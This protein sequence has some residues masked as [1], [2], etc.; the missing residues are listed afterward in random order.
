MVFIGFSCVSLTF[1]FSSSDTGRRSE[2]EAETD[3]QL[4]LNS[5]EHIWD[6]TTVAVGDT[7]VLHCSFD[8]LFQQLPHGNVRLYR[9]ITV[10][11]Q[12]TQKFNS[13]LVHSAMHVF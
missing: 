10:K 9:C 2:N 11:G 1:F 13:L 6:T 8:A 5:V 3:I 4:A 7:A 12:L